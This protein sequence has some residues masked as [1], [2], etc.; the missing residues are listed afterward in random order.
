M[1]CCL[2]LQA[3]LLTGGANQIMCRCEYSISEVPFMKARSTAYLPHR[4]SVSLKLILTID[5]THVLPEGEEECHD[6]SSD[7]EEIQY[8]FLFSTYFGTFF[9]FTATHLNFW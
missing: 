2:D 1:G 3:D 5:M 4:V 7:N 6:W 8:S 9:S